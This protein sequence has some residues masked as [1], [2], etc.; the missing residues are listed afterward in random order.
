V[1][2]FCERWPRPRCVPLRVPF[3][4]WGASSFARDSISSAAYG[5]FVSWSRLAFVSESRLLYYKSEKNNF[6][7]ANDK[8]CRRNSTFMI[9]GSVEVVLGGGTGRPS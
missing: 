2:L 1:T 3:A 5:L 6:I 4:F 8:Q 9:F 7:W